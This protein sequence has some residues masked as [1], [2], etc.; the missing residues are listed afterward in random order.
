MLLMLHY[1]S[2]SRGPAWF[3]QFT[4]RAQ[5]AP[6]VTGHHTGRDSEQPGRCLG[7]GVGKAGLL[8]WGSYTLSRHHSPQTSTGH[9][10]G[11]SLNAVLWVLVEVPSR[12]QVEEIS[13]RLPL[14]QPLPPG[15]LLTGDLPWRPASTLRGPGAS[16]S[17][18]V[19]RSG[20]AHSTQSS[21]ARHT[22]QVRSSSCSVCPSGIGLPPAP[23]TE[24][25]KAALSLLENGYI[26]LQPPPT[27]GVGR[28]KERTDEQVWEAEEAGSAHA[29]RFPIP[30]HSERTHST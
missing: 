22:T 6:W 30:A 23:T 5:G 1:R 28:T 29:C 7:G 19:V 13:T 18:L 21:A 11:S 10:P 26:S 2:G 3:G 9:S 25:P 14:I 27:K 8:G 24:S 15:P 17:H 12:G 20:Q 4:H 16:Q